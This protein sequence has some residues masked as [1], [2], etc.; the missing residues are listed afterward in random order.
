MKPTA[1]I[2]QA[3]GTNRDFDAAGAL[4]LAGANPECVPLNHLREK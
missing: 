4:S 2:L 3:R 1:L